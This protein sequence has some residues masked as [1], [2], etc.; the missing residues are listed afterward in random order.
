M[1]TLACRNV[2]LFIGLT[3]VPVLGKSDGILCR[4]NI[5]DTVTIA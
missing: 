4:M 5:D 2:R 1:I 3:V